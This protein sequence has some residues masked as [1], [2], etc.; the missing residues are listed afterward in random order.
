VDN[1]ESLQK[2]MKAVVQLAKEHPVF[3]SV[4][5][6]T[7]RKLVEY[8]ISVGEGIILLEPLLYDDFLFLW[9]DALVVITDSGGLQ[10]ETN[11]LNVPCVTIRNNT[12]RP[13]TLRPTGTNELVKAETSVILA[14]VDRAEKRAAGHALPTYLDGKAADK[15]VN[16]L[17][18]DHAL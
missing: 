3:F 2:I 10:S 5:P 1:E 8:K 6:R 12:E 9:K 14:A 13:V 17:L 11:F 15:I 7:K 18:E 16:I 4:H